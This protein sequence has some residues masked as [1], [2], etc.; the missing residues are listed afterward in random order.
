MAWSIPWDLLG[1]VVHGDVG[2]YTVYTD[3]FGRK[4]VF[5]KLPPEKPHTERQRVQRQRFQQAV[6]AWKTL[7]EQ[8]KKALEDAARKLSLVMTGQNLFISIALK[9]GKEL[10]ETIEAQSG[11]TLPAI[12][13]L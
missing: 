2:G 10:K 11:I 13:E 12:P 6:K 7:S 3:R 9:H 5:P 4:T 8:E 1:L